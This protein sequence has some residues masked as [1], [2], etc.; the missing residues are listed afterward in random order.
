VTKQVLFI[1]GAGEGAYD[2]DQKLAESLQQSLGTGY[3]VVYPAMPSE[4]D[5]PPEQWQQLIDKELAAMP[6]PVVLVGH[7]VGASVILRWLSERKADAPITGIFLLASP[8]WGGDG[9]RYEGYEKLA[10]PDGFAA[11]LPT[12]ISI[13]LYHCRDDEVVPFEHLSLYTRML[14][15]ARIQACDAGGHQFNNDLSAVAKD[16]KSLHNTR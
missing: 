6:G 13:A 7:S 12:G 4:D 14:P 1:Q 8:Y 3:A 5:A 2:E 10:L 9:W 15:Q 16:I 11:S